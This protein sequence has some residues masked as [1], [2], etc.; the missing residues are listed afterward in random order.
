MTAHLK[1]IESDRILN[2]ISGDVM[3]AIYS[4]QTMMSAY[5]AAGVRIIVT[6]DNIIAE[7]VEDDELLF[8]F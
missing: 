7:R 6:V 8:K 2:Q 5:D 4:L 3:N 1:A